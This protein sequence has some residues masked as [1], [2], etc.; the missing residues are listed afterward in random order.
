MKLS[1]RRFDGGPGPI[2]AY[3]W[4]YLRVQLAWNWEW[5]FFRRY[6]NMVTV[7]S[8]CAGCIC[9]RKCEAVVVREPVLRKLP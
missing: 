1:R 2:S 8:R 6:R 9:Q 3:G 5:S 4:R 7:S